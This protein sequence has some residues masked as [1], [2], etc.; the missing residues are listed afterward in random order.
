MTDF[1]FLVFFLHTNSARPVAGSNGCF[2]IRKENPV[3]NVFA[4]CNVT[5]SG[6][7]IQ[8]AVDLQFAMT[9]ERTVRDLFQKLCEDCGFDAWGISGEDYVT[10]PHFFTN[11]LYVISYVVSNDAAFQLYQLEQA[12][13]GAGLKLYEEQLSSS[14]TAFLSFAESA[15]L[16]SPFAENRVQSIRE[17]LEEIL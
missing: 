1:P 11:P 13:P 14:E 17:T 12:E 9:T 8:F 5:V 7:T 3:A 16:T 2:L 15:G 10:I 6:R 4:I